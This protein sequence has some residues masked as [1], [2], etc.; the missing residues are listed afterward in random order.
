MDKKK[1]DVLFAVEKPKIDWRVICVGMLCLTLVELYAISQGHNGTLRML[2]FA[3][4]AGAIGVTI[5][6]PLKK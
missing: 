5:Q 2:F 6:N 4:V 3:L 1:V